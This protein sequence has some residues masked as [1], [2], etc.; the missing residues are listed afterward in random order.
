MGRTGDNFALLALWL[1][2]LNL[3]Y[4]PT[5]NKCR[6]RVLAGLLAA[7]V[8]LYTGWRPQAN[9]K[10]SGSYVYSC[11]AMQRTALAVPHAAPAAVA[12]PYIY[13]NLAHMT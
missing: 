11:M 1:Q 12:T 5:C 2:L 8:Y 13:S 3:V 4:V 6:V 9:L 10:G 7:K